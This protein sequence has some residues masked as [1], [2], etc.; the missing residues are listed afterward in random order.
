MK[1]HPFIPTLSLLVAAIAT[2]HTADPWGQPQPLPL[3]SD[4]EIKT[5]ARIIVEEADD[6]DF[7]ITLSGEI[8]SENAWMT[9]LSEDGGVLHDAAVPTGNLHTVKIPKDGT[10]GRYVILL[11]VKRSDLIQTPLTDLP[12]EVYP[13][14]YWMLP[15]IKGDE[16]NSYFVRPTEQSGEVFRLVPGKTYFTVESLGGELLG[17]RRRGE[18]TEEVQEFPFPEEG[19]WIRLGGIYFNYEKNPRTLILSDSPERWFEPSEDLLRL[20]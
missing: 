2:V 11:K 1:S 16:I 15:Q 4:L 12:K 19:V 5:P 17:E 20:E 10:A 18:V 7:T 13:V 6:Q 9:V 14:T 3:S 8:R